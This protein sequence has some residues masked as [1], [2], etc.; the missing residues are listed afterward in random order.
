MPGQKELLIPSGWFGA[1]GISGGAS[2]EITGGP[3]VVAPKP[4]SHPDE[5]LS[6]TIEDVKPWTEGAHCSAIVNCRDGELYARL[7]GPGF[8]DGRSRGG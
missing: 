2:K 1:G 5:S 7:G 4:S 8:L 3:G 6:P